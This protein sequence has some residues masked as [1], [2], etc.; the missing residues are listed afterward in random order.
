MSNE[1]AAPPAEAA[2][3]T[4]LEAVEGASAQLGALSVAE[5]RTLMLRWRALC[6]KAPAL[7]RAWRGFARLLMH[8]QEWAQAAAAFQRA[9]Q[10]DPS[11]AGA[12]IGQAR[13]L[14]MAGDTVGQLRLIDAALAQD[15]G[16]GS[17]WLLLADLARDKGDRAGEL[18]ALER[19]LARRP[20]P[21]PVA[22]RALHRAL[23]GGDPAT[24]ARLGRLGIGQHP[25]DPTLWLGLGEAFGRRGELQAAEDALQRAVGLDAN[26]AAAWDALGSVRKRQGKL[27]AAL[28]AHQRAVAL[29]PR[30]VGARS[31]AA[32]CWMQLDNLSEPVALLKEGIALGDPLSA[33]ATTLLQPMLHLADWWRLDELRAAADAK[34]NEALGAGRQSPLQPIHELTNFD[35]PA[36]NLAVARSFA[37]KAAATRPPARPVEGPLTL[38]YHSHDMRNHPMGHLT[39]GLYARHDRRRF[40]V[41]MLSTGPNDGSAWRARAEAGVDR[42]IDAHNQ[43]EAALA[44]LVAEVQPHIFIDLMG[45][46]N[47][48]RQGLFARRLAPLQLSWLGFPGSTGAA[49]FDGLLVD[50]VL[51]T[52]PAH[53]SEPLLP[54]STVYQPTDGDQPRPQRQGSRTDH[55]LPEDGIVFCSFN[56]VYK[57]DPEGWA[58]WMRMLQ[59][60]PGSAL[61]LLDYGPLVRGRLRKA[62]SEAGI[63]PDRLVF[64][65]FVHRDLHLARLGHADLALDT[66]LYGG[67]T[68]TSDALWAGVP[69][70]T[71]LGRHFASRVAASILSHAGL[72]ALVFADPEAQQRFV[73]GWA[74]DP[75]ARAALRAKVLEVHR[76][77]G[78]FDTDHFVAALDDTLSAR[79][80]AQVEAD[81]R[82]SGDAGPSP[83]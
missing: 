54:L 71:V 12:R 18:Q 16:D 75:G 14:G 73:E 31:R 25:E 29:A 2:L 47:G 52:D 38:L 35:E 57:L 74:A 39:I 10:L 30:L 3:M 13:A 34:V 64:A 24:A 4:E 76:P 58:R 17:A 41:V 6:A 40:R 68:T 5:A 49:H 50:R 69:V 23:A 78:I 70:I 36:R 43:P 81:R 72:E 67:H 80:A 79:W 45:H 27:Q 53:F 63:D 46:T 37:P 82:A 20:T 7:P 32:L 22:R 26:L 44:A 1:R 48:N 9:H 65:P 42:F 28:L 55:G 15:P 11:D 19:C 59:A 61:W 62:A 33:Y 66:R 21:L 83:A 56:Q 51:A 8:R 77:Q 60:A